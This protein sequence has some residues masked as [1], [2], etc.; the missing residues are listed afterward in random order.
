MNIFDNIGDTKQA[1]EL[2]GMTDENVKKLAQKGEINAKK[3]G[4]SWAI[5]LSQPNPKKYGGGVMRDYSKYINFEEERVNY[6]K[7]NGKASISVDFA[8]NEIITDVHQMR[9]YEANTIML[10]CF[11]D[12]FTGGERIGKERLY[13]LLE[14]MRDKFESGWTKDDFEMYGVSEFAR[15]FR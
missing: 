3:I 1:G 13:D 6:N 2:W 7:F 12:D 15:F 4:N 10:V 14:A 5:D 9:D 11:K 8:D